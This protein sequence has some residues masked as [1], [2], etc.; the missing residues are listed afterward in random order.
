MRNAMRQL[1]QSKKSAVTTDDLL[2]AVA[3][4]RRRDLLR[5]LHENE[6]DVI[7][8]DQL[9]DELRASDGQR[10][11]SDDLERICIQLRHAHLP[12][13]ADT[14]ALAFDSRTGTVRCCRD[15]RVEK[16]LL[17]VAAELE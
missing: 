11:F 7:G 1:M 5:H 16:L 4:S 10:S 3:D 6:V 17:F 2:E 14:G 15:E 13:L 9:A 8:V 12:K